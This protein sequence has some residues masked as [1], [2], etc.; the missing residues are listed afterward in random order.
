MKQQDKK[1]NRKVT[2]VSPKKRNKKK[3]LVIKRDR[4]GNPVLWY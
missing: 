1:Q 4:Q 3:R 2:K